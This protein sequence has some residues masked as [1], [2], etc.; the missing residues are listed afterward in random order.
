V[1]SDGEGGDRDRARYIVWF[2]R[3][4]AEF[5]SR[6]DAWATYGGQISIDE[7][8]WRQLFDGGLTPE[9]AVDEEI[10]AAGG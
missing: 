2:H 6:G 5:I 4:Q 1:K 10:G 3:L 7:P 9:E 8:A